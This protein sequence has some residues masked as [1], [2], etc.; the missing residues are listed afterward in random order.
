MGSS[1]ELV[2]RQAL[3]QLRV[4]LITFIQIFGVQYQFLLIAVLSILSVSLMTTLERY[5]L[6]L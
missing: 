1:I 3:I 6:I 4:F 5:G 2:S